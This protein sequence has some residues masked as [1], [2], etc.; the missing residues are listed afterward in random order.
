[1][2][3]SLNLCIFI[4]AYLLVSCLNFWDTYC[5]DSALKLYKE[6]LDEC[7]K[8]INCGTYSLS[9]LQNLVDS[10]QKVYDEC[11]RIEKYNERINKYNDALKN[12]DYLTCLH[13]LE[14]AK[15]YADYRLQE[16]NNQIQNLAEYLWGIYAQEENYIEALKYY[17]KALSISE[18]PE[19]LYNVWW[20]C[21]KLGK[22]KAWIP[23]LNKA[24]QKAKDSKLLE[25]ITNLLNYMIE[26]SEYEDIKKNWKA[27]DEYWFY[28]YYLSWIDVFDAWDKLPQN[29]KKVIIAVIDDG[30]DVNHPDFSGRIRANRK[31]IL[32]D[33]IDN[34]KNWYVDDYNW[35]NF[36][37]NNNWIS[38]PWNHGTMVA[39]II[40]ANTNNEI[41]ISWIV[42]DVEIM[43]LVVFWKDWSANWNDII[44]AINYAVDNGANIINL[45]LVQE[46]ETLY[47]DYYN[48]AL[49]R[50][51]KKWIIVVASAWN[52]DDLEER[53][54]INTTK[55]KISP[56][57]NESDKKNVIW[58][59]S[60][61]KK[62]TK[63]Q[64]SNYWECVDFYMYWEDI[65]TTAVNPD[66]E[67]YAKA[68]WTSFSAPIVSG[69]IWLWY[70]MFWWI[71]PDSVYDNL[72]NSLKNNIISASKYLDRL[73]ISVWE[74]GDAIEWLIDNWF[75]VAKTTD[76]FYYNRIVRRDEAAKFFVLFANMFNRAIVVNSDDK[77]IFS[78]LWDSHSD[79]KLY[80][81]NACRYW[82]LTWKNW[83]FMPRSELTNAQAITAFMRIIVW[84][85]DENWTHF[86]DRYFIQAYKLWLVQWLVLWNQ[87]NYENKS[88]RWELAIL[89]YRWYKILSRK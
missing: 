9:S 18:N 26:M 60:I 32:W 80:V 58:V 53:N 76:E 31:E 20:I 47:N 78:D 63:S 29:K 15:K 77:C 84:R 45:S 35:W 40:A 54:G 86:A 38:S 27:N 1:M 61:S 65:Y 25:D 11:M 19:T 5:S 37:E 50:A 49:K 85:L 3:K 7:K 52:W 16:I 22:Y 6:N 4:F 81:I 70:N 64:W 46:D 12:Q 24:K 59:W 28:Q 56:V 43:P 36:V 48:S 89:L 17:K 21:Y 71:S 51:N 69:I 8:D 82:L 42:P 62:W 41:W 2:K 14:E 68:E 57:C 23:Y 66:W 74:L 75:T 87:N 67:P 30:I 72:N 88:K 13:A 44:E 39:W 33:G 79:L 10:E 83:K 73:S 55:T 34:D